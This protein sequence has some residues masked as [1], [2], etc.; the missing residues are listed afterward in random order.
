ME[1]VEAK[2][3]LLI[4]FNVFF[5]EDETAMTRIHVH[6]DAASIDFH[7]QVMTQGV[8]EDMVGWI[9]RADFLEP[10]HIEIYGTPQRKVIGS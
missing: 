7:M 10:K 3:P 9:D 8:G 1:L 4:A 2:E 5:N 6:P